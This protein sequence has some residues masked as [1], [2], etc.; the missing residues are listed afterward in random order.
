MYTSDNCF[1]CD[2]SLRNPNLF[3]L[4]IVLCL[5]AIYMCAGEVKFVDF[6]KYC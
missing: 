2:V 3:P 4:Y 1:I 6:S 5:L